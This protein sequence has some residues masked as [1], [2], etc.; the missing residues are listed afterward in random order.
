MKIALVRGPFLRPS[1]V[2]PWEYLH[3]NS[4]EYD[5]TA[6]TSDPS[7][8]DTTPLNMPVESLPWY[9]GS[10]SML[11]FDHFFY[12]AFCRF[13]LPRAILGG[14]KDLVDQYDIIH[15]S[16]NFNI[17]SAQAA[18][19]C[20]GRE[21][22]FTF[23]AGENIPFYP[24]T[25][26]TS[27]HKSYVNERA[28]GA[29]ATTIQGKRALIHE[30]LPHSKINVIPNAV[31]PTTFQPASVTAA[32]AGLSFDLD[33]TFVLLFV[34]RL[35][36]QKGTPYL[37]DAFEKF[38]YEVPQSSLILVGSNQLEDETTGKRIRENPDIYHLEHVPHDEIDTLYNLADVFVLPSVTMP[39]NEEQFGMALIEAMATGTP[40]VVSNVGGL[41]HVAQ[42]RKT[43]LVVNERSV[44][45]LANAFEYLYD[46]E[47]LRNQMGE[48]S[49]D[50]SL[51]FFSPER[52]AEKLLK[53]YDNL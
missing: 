7:R 1:G 14:M 16:E 33:D 17:F 21:T 36:E 19:S 8:F 45:E 31:D 9:D 53:F 32:D 22:H 39:Y 47:A 12:R 44:S 4:S 34:H 3:Q 2:R 28:D 27:V 6:F 48:R 15:T 5:I 18:R 20:T 24:H 26:P 35:C 46:N 13:K 51:N 50:K 23:T 11:G 49:R 52:T 30:G 29:T 41:P 25:L 43:S 10:L 37:V 42:H 40:S 38:Q